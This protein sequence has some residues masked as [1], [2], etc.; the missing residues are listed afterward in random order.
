MKISRKREREREREDCQLGQDM[1][2]RLAAAVP[3]KLEGISVHRDQ[4]EA[5]GYFNIYT[6]QVTDKCGS[7]WPE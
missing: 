3:G 4:E 1:K 2:Q 5:H 7:R 6:Y